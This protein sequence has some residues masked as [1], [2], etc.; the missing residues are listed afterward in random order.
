MEYG[1]LKFHFLPNVISNLDLGLRPVLPNSFIPLLGCQ[2]LQVYDSVDSTLPVLHLA[3]EELD[4]LV[5]EVW[6][7]GHDWMF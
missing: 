2:Q 5:G 7:F 6:L 4:V 1:E 3:V